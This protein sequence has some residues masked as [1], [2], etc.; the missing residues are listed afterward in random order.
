[1]KT[2]KHEL[3]DAFL[4]KLTE[5]EIYK[6]YEMALLKKAKPSDGIGDYHGN[7][8]LGISIYSRVAKTERDQINGIFL[9]G[10]GHKGYESFTDELPFGIKF[11]NSRAEVLAILGKPDWSIEKGGEGIMA[12]TNSADK[13][14]T[15][16]KEGFRIEYATDDKSI[17]L[18]SIHCAKQ[19][20]EWA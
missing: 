10:K 12:I 11:T 9:Y 19:E 6:K 2:I 5:S 20:A 14:F 17:S 15:A 1:M 13:W 16:N 4:S 7:K 8:K 18:I 3:F